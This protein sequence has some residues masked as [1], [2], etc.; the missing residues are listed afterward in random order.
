MPSIV[1][2]AKPHYPGGSADRVYIIVA[3]Q[4]GLSTDEMVGSVI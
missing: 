2:S 3:V 4:S 1:S